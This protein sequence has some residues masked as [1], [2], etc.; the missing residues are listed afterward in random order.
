MATAISVPDSVK[1]RVM[2]ENLAFA[3]SSIASPASFT[4]NSFNLLFSNLFTTKFYCNVTSLV[5]NTYIT[6]APMGR[7]I[8]LV[9][10]AEGN[11]GSTELRKATEL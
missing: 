8:A 11:D 7:P 1:L 6:G 5:T 10:G 2:G 3:I 9:G 4:G